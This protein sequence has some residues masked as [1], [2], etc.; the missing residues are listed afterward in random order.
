MNDE[1]MHKVH[2]FRVVTAGDCKGEGGTEVAVEASGMG[3]Y[4]SGVRA[5]PVMDRDAP[6]TV[7][8]QAK[9]RNAETCAK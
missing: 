8:E 9:A 4:G 3:P 6:L 1:A 5:A 2:T 7:A